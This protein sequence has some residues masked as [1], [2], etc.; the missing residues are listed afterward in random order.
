MRIDANNFCFN[1]N[2]REVLVQALKLFAD[3]RRRR[4]AGI[5]AS[6]N[7]ADRLVMAKEQAEMSLATAED[8]ME[9]L[10]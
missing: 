10:A 1:A 2:E 3:G 4:V 9:L 6:R 7:T 8:L 5:V